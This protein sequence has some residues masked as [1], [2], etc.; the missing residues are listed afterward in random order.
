[1]GLWSTS[2]DKV[3]INL[4]TEIDECEWDG[5]KPLPIEVY[6]YSDNDISYYHPMDLKGLY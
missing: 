4:H 1:M 2:H 3:I 6:R 5:L